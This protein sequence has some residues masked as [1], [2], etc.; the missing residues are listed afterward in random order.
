MT[1]RRMQ[2]KPTR[3][4]MNRASQT[5]RLP[6]RALPNKPRSDIEIKQLLAI[7][8]LCVR[9]GIK[10]LPI[11]PWSK[12]PIGGYSSRT[13]FTSWE[14]IVASQKQSRGKFRSSHWLRLGIFCRRRRWR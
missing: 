2:T 13:T 5:Q 1:D 7:L 6:A 4:P 14:E 11:A 8:E 10:I 3:G 9:K 12:E